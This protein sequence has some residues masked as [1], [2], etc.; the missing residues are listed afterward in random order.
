VEELLKLYEDEKHLLF[1][2]RSR[3]NRLEARVLFKVITSGTYVP[4]NL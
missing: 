2:H 4:H 3:L 1:L